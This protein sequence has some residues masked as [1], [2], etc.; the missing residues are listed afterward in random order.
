MVHRIVRATVHEAID[1]ADLLEGVSHHGGQD[2]RLFA[3][4]QTDRVS[5]NVVTV[6]ALTQVVLRA[7]LVVPGEIKGNP[8]D[9]DVL[10]T[11]RDPAGF[12]A[13]KVKD[14]PLTCAKRPSKRGYW[15]TEFSRTDS[16]A[17]TPDSCNMQSSSSIG[18]RLTRSRIFTC[19]FSMILSARRVPLLRTAKSVFSALRMTS[20]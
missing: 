14:T 8:S 11:N 4:S 20:A 6:L 2:A 9:L 10:L 16:R 1:R 7:Q 13:S 15:E 3:V 5:E 18:S 19:P 17:S 12:A